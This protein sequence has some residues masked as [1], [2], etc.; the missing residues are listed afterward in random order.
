[1]RLDRPFAHVADLPAMYTGFEVLRDLTSDG[2][3]HLVA[4]HDP[5][6]MLRFPPIAS[7]TSGAP[8]TDTGHL[9]VR[10]GPVLPDALATGE[11]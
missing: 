2:T 11:R 10:I 9:G 1:M 4:G 7:S 3:R 6:V 8:D 5:E